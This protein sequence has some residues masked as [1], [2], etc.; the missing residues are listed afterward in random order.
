M[1][2]KLQI[3]WFGLP[4]WCFMKH[5]IS[6]IDYAWKYNQTFWVWPYGAWWNTDINDID[7]EEDI[8][9]TFCFSQ[10]GAWRNSDISSIDHVGEKTN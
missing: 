10:Y 6:N 1:F 4:V 2:V 7:E 5:W 3:K 9:N 8:N